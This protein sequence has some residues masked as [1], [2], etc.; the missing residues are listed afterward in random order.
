MLISCVGYVEDEVASGEN[1]Q[2]VM[3]DMAEG[4]IERPEFRLV[5]VPPDNRPIIYVGALFREGGEVMLEGWF[6][7]HIFGRT[8]VAYC[9]NRSGERVGHKHVLL[10]GAPEAIDT[11]AILSTPEAVGL[12]KS[13]AKGEPLTGFEQRDF[14]LVL[15]RDEPG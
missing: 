9:V 15:W 14:G 13:Y 5:P 11:S 4:I 2:Q 8:D 3:T 10:C 12:L 1:I 7:W 6:I